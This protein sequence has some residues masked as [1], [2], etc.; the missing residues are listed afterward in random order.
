MKI[1]AE[2]KNSGL[3][4]GKEVVQVYIKDPGSAIDKPDKE[5]KGYT[6]VFLEP[7]ESKTVSLE[8]S[9]DQF[10]HYDEQK[11][12][13]VV[14]PGQFEILLGSSSRDIRIRKNIFIE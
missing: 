2:I 12:Q 5:L 9:R 7:G 4:P 13:W 6:K 1:D 11:N 10:A 14:E 8:L 3:V